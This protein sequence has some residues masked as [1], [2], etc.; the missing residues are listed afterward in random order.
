M[1]SRNGQNDVISHDFSYKKNF[2]KNKMY[3]LDQYR[4]VSH[5]TTTIR[6]LELFPKT[7]CPFFYKKLKTF[8][9]IFLSNKLIIN[10]K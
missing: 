10:N 8:K 6:F 4:S 9:N 3:D 1:K 5:K 7:F 2:F